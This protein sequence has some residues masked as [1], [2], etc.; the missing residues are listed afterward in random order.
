MKRQLIAAVGVAAMVVGLAAC[1]S[2][3]KS[4]GD[5]KE[6]APTALTVWLTVDAQQN[7]PD[8]VKSAD[9]A[10]TAK[11]PG[12]KINHEYYGW[13][14]KNTKLDSVLATDAVPDVVEMG[15]TEMLPYMIKGALAPLDTAKFENS[16]AWLDGLKASATYN[17]KTYGVPYYAGARVA[18]WRKDIAA[19]AGVTAVPTTYA[20]LTAALDKIQAKQGDKFSAWYQP[21]RDWYTAMSFV[22]DAGGSIAKQDG[23]KWKASLSTPESIKGLTA[24]KDAL[25]KYMKGDLTKDDADRYIV[26][27]LGSS[28]MIYG[29][30]WE[31]GSAADPKFDK[32]GGTLKD[33]LVSFVMPGPSGKNLSTF[34]GGSDLAVPVKS[35]AKTAASEWINAFTNTKAQEVLIKA[36]NL[37]NNK[38]QL[39]PLKADPK[40]A[41][42]ATAAEISWFVPTAPGWLQVEKANI[43]Q[44]ALQDIAQGKKTVEEAAK[45][46]DTAIDAVINKA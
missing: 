14:D 16:S 46:A 15:N 39:A 27:G 34:L 41:P 11:Y 8:L 29:S 2:D 35:K 22:T 12:I 13:K 19:G 28:N 3:A 42:T 20:D 40:T 32:T 7:W 6:A 45:A 18:T 10:I 17:G 1:G 38:T 25:G 37:P 4:G 21:S 26:Y 24:W 36:G 43:L 9:D 23:D 5:A 30:G 44:N 31:G 33:N